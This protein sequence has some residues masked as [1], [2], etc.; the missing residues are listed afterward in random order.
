MKKV[1]AFPCCRR[2]KNVLS[3]CAI[4]LSLAACGGG[5]DAGVAAPPVSAPEPPAAAVHSAVTVGAASGTVAAAQTSFPTEWQKA[6]SAET[7]APKP[8][9]EHEVVELYQFL[10]GRYPDP[11]GLKFWTDVANSEGNTVNVERGMRAS[12]EYASLT[13]RSSLRRY[14]S[15]SGRDSNTGSTRDSPW[16]LARATTSVAPGTVVFVLPGT[17]GDVK[18]HSAGNATGRIRYVSSLPYCAKI[19]GSS[20]RAMWEN[21]GDYTD[22]AGF[23]VTGSGANGILN[24]AS[25]TRVVGN[26]VHHLTI[27]NFVCDGNGGS[28]INNAN[29][30]AREGRGDIIGNVVHDIGIPGTCNRVQGIYSSRKGARIYNNVVF[31]AASVGIHLWHAAEDTIIANNTVFS[32]GG[33]HPAT[34]PNEKPHL[35]GGGIYAG[36]VAKQKS[37]MNNVVIINNIVF[38]NPRHGIRVYCEH[39]C[40]GSGNRIAH[41]LVNKSETRVATGKVPATETLDADPQFVN[42]QRDGTGNYRLVVGSPAI[43][44]GTDRPGPP[45]DLDGVPGRHDGRLDLGAYERH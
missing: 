15:P 17:Y 11:E 42:Y 1:A 37:K 4:V 14:A 12:L 30:T 23:D 38:D 24:H 33:L 6:G 8:G 9:L 41:N 43:D 10:L 5:D 39:D 34:K 22:I 40:Y 19:K 21:K 3:C 44:R 29:Y 32:N 13:E 27:N 18:T 28:G 31:R 2:V 16:S 20:E 45:T 26:Y 36:V 7:C 35:I 25:F